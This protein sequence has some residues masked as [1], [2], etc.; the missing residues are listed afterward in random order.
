LPLA[1]GHYMR[2]CEG[3]PDQRRYSLWTSRR[4]W[5]SAQPPMFVVFFKGFLRL[6]V[7][8]YCR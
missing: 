5:P 6:F 4:P 3:T 8:R 7:F 1:D 2:M